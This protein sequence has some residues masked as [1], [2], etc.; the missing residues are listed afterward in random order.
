MVVAV[1]NNEREGAETCNDKEELAAYKVLWEVSG[2]GIPE[3]VEK[4]ND[5]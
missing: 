1:V 2:E 5:R 3:V 4:C